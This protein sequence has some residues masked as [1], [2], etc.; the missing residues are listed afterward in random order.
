MPALGIAQ[1][2]YRVF[3]VVII[4]GTFVGG[5][6]GLV[7]LWSRSLRWAQSGYVRSYAFM[8]LIGA[9]LLVMFFLFRL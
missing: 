4:D 7:G 2:C 5:A 9:V 3:D 6:A 1:L 8:T